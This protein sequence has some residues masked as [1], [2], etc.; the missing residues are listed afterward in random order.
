MILDFVALAR[1]FLWFFYFV[2]AKANGWAAL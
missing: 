1:Y 2:F